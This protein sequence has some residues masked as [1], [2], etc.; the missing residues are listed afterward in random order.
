MVAR[1]TDP[2]QWNQPI[3][4][5]RGL[6]TPFFLRQWQGQ[7]QLNGDTLDL[8]GISFVAGAG[9]TG[10]GA[11]SSL[12]NITFALDQEFAQDLVAALIDNTANVTWTYNDAGASLTADLTD[13]A[14]TPG[15][16]ASADITVDAK[17]RI[18]AAADGAGGGSAWTLAGE[19]DHGVS[20]NTAVPIAFT[21]LAD[22]SELLVVVTGT[23][24]SVSGALSVEVSVDDGAN[25]FTTAGD[26]L[27]INAS[28]A[29][30]SVANLSMASGNSAL[31][32]GGTCHIHNLDVF[33]PVAET[34]AGPDP[35]QF[36]ASTSDINAIRVNSSGGGNLTAGNIRVY[37]R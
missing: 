27:Q 18:T 11:L 2:L 36:V 13:T 23:T 20:G 19:W 17:G 8:F 4:D 7:K 37:G 25:Y 21:G 35:Y 31:T 30:T 14:V 22:Y 16:Y 1:S 5:K 26:Y 28:G 24:K 6:P 9:L 12:S 29:Q 34:N 33:P 3:V 15:S 10:G 32:R